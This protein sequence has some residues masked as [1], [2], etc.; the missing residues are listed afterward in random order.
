MHRRVVLALCFVTAA[1]FSP[2]ADGLLSLGNDLAFFLVNH[3]F[4]HLEV[5][6]LLKGL[7]LL[8][9][10]AGGLDADLVHARVALAA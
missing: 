10:A 2:R 3:E 6:F 4:E 5:L 8:V 9:E 7:H 1:A